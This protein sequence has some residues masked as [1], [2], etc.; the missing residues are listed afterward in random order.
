MSVTQTVGLVQ[1]LAIVAFAAPLHGQTHAT[2]IGVG[3]TFTLTRPGDR[4]LWGVGA[5]IQSSPTGALVYRVRGSLQFVR[6]GQGPQPLLA[7]AGLDFGV[8]TGGGLDGMSLTL[9]PSLFYYAT[10][11]AIERYCITEDSCREWNRGYDPGFLLVITATAGLEYAIAAGFSVFLDGSLHVPSGIGRNGFAGDPTAAFPGL[12][13][14]LG[15]V[16]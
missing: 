5:R 15:F 8:R 3:P 1:F 7:T 12:S 13:F 16:P 4:P 2:I 14:G 11:R 9:G 6:K 10:G